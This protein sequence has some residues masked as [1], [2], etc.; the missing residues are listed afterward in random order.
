[1]LVDPHRVDQGLRRVRVQ[2]DGVLAGEIDV[3]L[4]PLAPFDVVDPADIDGEPARLHEFPGLASRRL[5]RVNPRATAGHEEPGPDDE[6]RHTDPS[7]TA[8]HGRPW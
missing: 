8:V 2:D 4:T 6:D 1:M 5:L 3:S 7:R